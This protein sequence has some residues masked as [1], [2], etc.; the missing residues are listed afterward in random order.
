[1][2]SQNNIQD[3]AYTKRNI[4][5]AIIINGY[6]LKCKEPPLKDNIYRYKSRKKESKYFFY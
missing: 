2:E 5:K 4:V 3:E 6:E 1:M